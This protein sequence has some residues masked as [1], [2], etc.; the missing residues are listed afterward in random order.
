[1]KLPNT[2]GKAWLWGELVY[3]NVFHLSNLLL[4]SATSIWT[5]ESKECAVPK[6][7]VISKNAL[8]HTII[9]SSRLISTQLS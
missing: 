9:L 1:M 6:L 2:S 7:M 5:I 4:R 3:A 8:M